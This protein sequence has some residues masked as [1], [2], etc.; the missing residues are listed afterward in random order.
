MRTKKIRLHALS[1]I[2]GYL[3]CL[4]WHAYFKPK[5]HQIIGTPHGATILD[6]IM[7]NEA[8]TPPP[9]QIMDETVK[10]WY[11]NGQ[12]VHSW[13]SDSPV[14]TFVPRFVGRVNVAFHMLIWKTKIFQKNGL[15][16]A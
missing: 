2:L 16:N 15:M 12:W 3:V 9:P 6:I 7:K 4:S 14:K 8:A 1:I 10:K 13:G 5:D 11:I